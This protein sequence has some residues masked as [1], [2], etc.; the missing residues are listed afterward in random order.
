M[1]SI[2]ISKIMVNTNNN[3]KNKITT[4]II[5]NLHYSLFSHGTYCYIII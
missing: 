5:K 4:T 2:I 1:T 3:N